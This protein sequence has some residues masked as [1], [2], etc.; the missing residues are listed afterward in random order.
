M[1]GIS[2]NIM[3]GHC[4]RLTSRGVLSTCPCSKNLVL[5]GPNKSRLNEK[6]LHLC[7]GLRRLYSARNKIL[8]MIQRT[9]I[10][11]KTH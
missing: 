3:I 9:I 5:N 1:T 11:L 4:C 10:L 8:K 2:P 7:R 6:G